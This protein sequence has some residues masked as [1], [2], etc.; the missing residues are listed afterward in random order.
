MLKPTLSF[1]YDSL[2]IH[3]FKHETPELDHLMI[4]GMSGSGMRSV[5][6]TC[7]PI[8]ML[9]IKRLQ[10]MK[11]ISQKESE[12]ILNGIQRSPDDV[13]IPSLRDRTSEGH[14]R[15]IDSQGIQRMQDA[16]SL[17]SVNKSELLFVLSLFACILVEDGAEG[18]KS[19]REKSIPSN[20][21]EHE[22]K[23]IRNRNGNFC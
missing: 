9:Q 3:R 6:Y 12:R 18:S 5:M 13:E 10:R 19:K 21:A 16:S 8:V 15:E 14:E 20:L 7:A 17:F 1:P 23:C 11:F 22:L 4:P 2:I